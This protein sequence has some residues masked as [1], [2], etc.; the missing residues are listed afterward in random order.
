MSNNGVVMT[1]ES[2]QQDSMSG[3]FPTNIPVD[4]ANIEDL[5]KG[6]RNLRIGTDEL[7]TNT[8]L[9]QI[10]AH[11]EISDGGDHGDTGGD[12]VEETVCARLGEGEANEGE[13]GDNHHSANSLSD[14]SALALHRQHCLHTQYQSDP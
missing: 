7:W 5:S 10:G 4:V 14:E 8:R 9:A 11:G 2:R 1:L 3:T 12:V 13:S 6:A